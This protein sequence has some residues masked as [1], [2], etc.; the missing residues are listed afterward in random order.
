MKYNAVSNYLSSLYMKNN[1][2]YYI[3][4]NNYTPRDYVISIIDRKTGN[5]AGYVMV[6]FT[7]S[8]KSMLISRGGT[9]NK[10]K[11]QGLGELLR[12]LATKL[13]QIANAKIAYQAG[14]FTNNESRR[15]GVPASTRILSR[16]GWSINGP[17]GKFIIS[18]FNYG[19]HNM[20]KVNSVINKRIYIGGPPFN[21]QR[22]R[23]AAKPRAR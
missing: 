10:Y 6:E 23:T 18:H 2:N 8:N 22:L 21:I 13:G 14:N 19:K 16:L 11:R 20:S 5:R 3:K 12:A 15:L 9:K 7:N 17:N 1:K 4:S